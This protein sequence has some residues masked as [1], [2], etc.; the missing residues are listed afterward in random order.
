MW[1]VTLRFE[2]ASSSFILGVEFG[3]PLIESVNMQILQCQLRH[4]IKMVKKKKSS[5]KF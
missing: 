2:I 1:W 5:A 4:F 3:G